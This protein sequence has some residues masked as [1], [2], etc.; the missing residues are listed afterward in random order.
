L[1]MFFGGENAWVLPHMCAL[2]TARWGF[3]P[4]SQSVLSPFCHRPTNA[5]IVRPTQK[6][7]GLQVNRLAKILRF[8]WEKEK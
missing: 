5:P 6:L 8:L 2:S 3:S 7:S 1:E 4:V